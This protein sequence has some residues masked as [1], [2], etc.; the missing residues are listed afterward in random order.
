MCGQCTLCKK[1]ELH[2][3]ECLA[4]QACAQQQEKV[5]GQWEVRS[6]SSVHETTLPPDIE[7]YTFGP[8]QR[9]RMIGEALYERAHRQYPHY[10]MKMVGMRMG[11]QHRIDTIDAVGQRLDPEL[12]RGVD[13]DIFVTEGN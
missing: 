1:E 2:T 8:E 3:T 4:A 10:A 5:S 6:P 11:E 12:G 9:K 7:L 13:Q